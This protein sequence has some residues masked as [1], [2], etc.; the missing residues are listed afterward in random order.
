MAIRYFKIL[1]NRDQDTWYLHQKESVKRDAYSMKFNEGYKSQKL[2]LLQI[3]IHNNVIRFTTNGWLFYSLCGVTQ[4][5]R[6]KTDT[7]AH[8]CHQTWRLRNSANNNGVLHDYAI[9]ILTSESTYAQ[10]TRD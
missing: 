8:T 9:Y 6:S 7:H 3:Y 4:V 1:R 5:I 2:L 10:R